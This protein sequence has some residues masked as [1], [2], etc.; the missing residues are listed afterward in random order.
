M[1]V[2]RE[3][4][5][6]LDGHATTRVD[7]AVLEAMLPYF[8]EHFGNAA[9]TGHR[10]G[11]VA[12][13]AVERARAQVARFVGATSREIVFTSGA[14][15]ANNLALK[16]VMNA[17]AAHGKRHL[18]TQATEHKAVLYSAR[19]LV[20]LGFEV[21]VL[22]VDSQGLV[23]PRA[24]RDAIREDTALVSIMF[25]NNELGTVQDLAAIG[26]ITRERGVLLHTDAAQGMGLVP[27][28]VDAMQVDLASF[29]AHKMYGPKGVGALF[30]RK[31][32][33]R[34]ELIAE[35]DGGGHENGARSGTLAVPNIVGLGAAAEVAQTRAEE[36]RVRVAQQRDRIADAVLAIPDVSLNG[37]K[38]A[39]HPGNLNVCF[40]GIDGNALLVALADTV[41]LSSGSACSSASTK[42]SYVLSAIG[43]SADEAHG[44]IRFGVGRFTTD[45]EITAVIDAVTKTVSAMRDKQARQADVDW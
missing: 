24:V 23:D 35:L 30:V 12:A 40:K 21:T 31:R 9:S 16:G 6:Y 5:I 22:D 45:E 44:S 2:K 11:G 32:E 39:R 20:R 14:T 36:D 8:T 7:P 43:L 4:P 1:D 33:V 13:R 34:V 26:A 37:A 19:R 17:A 42:P 27:F 25:V 3:K 18:I 38:D 15:E 10:Y 28:D 41:A 29:T